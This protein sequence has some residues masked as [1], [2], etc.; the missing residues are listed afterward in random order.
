MQIYLL[1]ACVFFCFAVGL[2]AKKG[3]FNN[4]TKFIVSVMVSAILISS[5]FWPITL[6]TGAIFAGCPLKK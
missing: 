1:I 3:E 4:K 6:V 5:L 2:A